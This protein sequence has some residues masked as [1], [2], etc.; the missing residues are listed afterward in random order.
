M[1][2][3]DDSSPLCVCVCVCVC[4]TTQATDA[5]LQAEYSTVSYDIVDGDVMGNFTINTTTGAITVTSPLDY[6][7]MSAQLNGTFTLTV[8]AL[9]VQRPSFSDNVTVHIHVHVMWSYAQCN[10][11]NS[12]DIHRVALLCR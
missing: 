10:S 7:M 2:G 4:G 11:T 9:D 12:R 3:V 8:M 1:V 6:E 5:D